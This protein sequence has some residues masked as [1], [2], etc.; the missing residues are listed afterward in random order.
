MTLAEVLVALLIAGLAVVGIVNG[1][2]FCSRSAERSA[3]S[4]TANGKAMERLEQTRGAKWDTT[5]W[6]AMDQLVATNFPQQVVVLERSGSGPGLL[7]ATNIVQ[8]SQISS[9]PPLRRI[10]VDCIWRFNGTQLITNSVET[11]RAPD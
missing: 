1:Y 5:T 8:I 2:I 10:H 4:L 7:Y 6:P 9:T 11:C 3:L